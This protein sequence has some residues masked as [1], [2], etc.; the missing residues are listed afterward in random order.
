[1]R[2]THLLLLL[3][4]AL[5]TQAKRPSVTNERLSITYI[6]TATEDGKI[7][8]FMSIPY[9]QDTG[10]EQ[11]FRHPIPFSPAAD[12]IVDATQPGA[13]CPQPVQPMKQDPWTRIKNISEDCLT[14]RISKPAAGTDNAAAERK[15]LPVMIW[16]HG[17]GHLVGTVYD[18]AYDPVGLVRASIDSG[19]P[20]LYV[21]MNY[22]L[23]IY[24]FPVSDSLLEDG[25][26][27]LGLRDQALALQW[28]QD[29]ISD[30][31]GDPDNVTVFGEDTGAS[32][33]GLHLLTGNNSPA[34]VPFRRVIAQS[35]SAM[36]AWP[37]NAKTSKDSFAA[38]AA[39]LGCI[40]ASPQYWYTVNCLRLFS[41]D[42]VTKTA[43]DVAYEFDPL[44]GFHAFG[45]VVDG[46][47]VPEQPAKAFEDGRFVKDVDFLFGW[48]VDE[49]SMETPTVIQSTFDA[50]GWLMKRYPTLTYPSAL[51]LMY[52]YLDGPHASR[53]EC[54]EAVSTAWCALSRL[55]RDA[56]VA[57]PLLT[58][59]AHMSLAGTPNIYLYELN[60]SAFAPVMESKGRAYLGAAHFSDVPYVFHNLQ[61]SYFISEE[62][63]L[64]LARWMASTWAAFASAGSPRVE[65]RK[66]EGDGDDE[67]WPFSFGEQWKT[68][69]PR[70]ITLKTIGGPSSGVRRMPFAERRKC[71]AVNR[72]VGGGVTQY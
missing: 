16:I 68:E 36:S 4:L 21:A 51:E 15:L 49:G 10:G 44:N 61:S 24:G 42:Q 7:E 56:T 20:V 58:Q 27:N 11:R 17:G 22:R 39:K 59:A 35:G 13:A 14:L 69:E 18:S 41:M 60:Q 32:D 5:L 66:H 37:G 2:A 63:D 19:N 45:P 64:K 9:G 12:T 57:C 34:K 6:G 71:E 48:D 46:S 62:R 54:H 3:P 65:G 31:G 28:V 23:N 50:A 55:V 47:I 72:I 67:E 29:N 30:F 40:A 25:L 52:L 53:D 70:Q 38:V 26:T 33:I 43:F 8:Q 1:M